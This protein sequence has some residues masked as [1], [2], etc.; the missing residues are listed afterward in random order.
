MF[1]LFITII[2][3]VY[4]SNHML[5]MNGERRVKRYAVNTEFGTLV[6]HGSIKIKKIK[7]N[8]YMQTQLIY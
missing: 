5:F 3:Y 4:K 1:K 2:Y 7:N 6:S 8:A